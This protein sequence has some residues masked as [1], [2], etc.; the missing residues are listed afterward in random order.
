[1]T[2]QV[3]KPSSIEIRRRNVHKNTPLFRDLIKSYTDSLSYL[4]SFSNCDDT[5]VDYIIVNY[6]A[7]HMTYSPDTEG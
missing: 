4:I 5:T 6:E 7:T 1:M 3:L 2:S